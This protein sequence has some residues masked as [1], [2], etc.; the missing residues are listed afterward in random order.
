MGDV[1]DTWGYLG[2]IPGFRALRSELGLGVGVGIGPAKKRLG[3]DQP[4][5]IPMTAPVV[6]ESPSPDPRE[7]LAFA[8]RN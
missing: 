1:Y 3:G 8:S 4:E 6:V 5:A 2:I 7:A